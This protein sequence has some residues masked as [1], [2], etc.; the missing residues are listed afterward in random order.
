MNFLGG[1][2]APDLKYESIHCR[3]R[4]RLFQELCRRHET[5]DALLFVFGQDGKNSVGNQG[6]LK[7][8]LA[9]TTADELFDGTVDD[10]DEPK[11]DAVLCITPTGASLYHTDRC[12]LRRRIAQWPNLTEHRVRVQELLQ[13]A[14][15]C[16][17]FK[18][19]SFITM[20]EGKD[21]M[22]G[23]PPPS[24]RSLLP[25]TLPS[26]VRECQG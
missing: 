15:A 11:E 22:Y 4:L 2:T 10:K 14:D 24:P 26:P 20:T 18:I 9:G 6:V 23:L 17:I 8:L 1:S 25:P 7:Y 19:R 3:H 13:D 16:E 21:N 12:K 5:L